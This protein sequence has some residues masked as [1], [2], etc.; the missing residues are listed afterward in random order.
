VDLLREQIE[1]SFAPERPPYDIADKGLVVWPGPGYESEI[2]YD[3]R[4]GPVLHPRIAEGQPPARPVELQAAQLLFSSR[5]L[6]WQSWVEAWE[7]DQSGVAPAEALLPD[8]RVLPVDQASDTDTDIP[9]LA[10]LNRPG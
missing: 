10:A 3:L 7:R 2:V 9:P 5:A 6:T 1:A 8:M 4:E